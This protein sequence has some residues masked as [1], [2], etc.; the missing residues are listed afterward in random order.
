MRGK[1]HAPHAG[2]HKHIPRD[3]GLLTGGHVDRL[4]CRRFQINALRLQ[5]DVHFQGCIA[6]VVDDCAH[7]RCI[8][9]H[10][11]TG[12]LHFDE[13]RLGADQF[14]RRLSHQRIRR[15]STHIHLP[16]G[17]VF[18]QR[19]AH[20]RLAFFVGHHLPG[21]KGRIFEVLTHRNNAQVAFA[22]AAAARTLAVYDAFLIVG[23]VIFGIKH[24]AHRCHHSQALLGIKLRKNRPRSGWRQR[25]DGFIHH[26]ERNLGWD[27]IAFFVFGHHC[28]GDILTGTGGHF[29]GR[30]ADIQALLAGI[31]VDARHAHFEIGRFGI[32]CAADHH[33]RD[34]RDGRHFLGDG[35][36]VNGAVALQQDDFFLVNM[37]ALKGHQ[38]IHIVREGLGDHN[39]GRIARLV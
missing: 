34:I 4:G 29:I 7:L 18:R 19:H 16:G 36:F 11:E 38:R 13:E 37:P 33:H 12:S 20:L 9:R 2:A 26:R 25:Q 28:V 1:V 10:K 32:F 31:H 30:D 24:N 21:I 8:V 23:V 5:R 35:Q 22:L 27:G 14:A 6:V 17:Q 3:V 15:H 39:F